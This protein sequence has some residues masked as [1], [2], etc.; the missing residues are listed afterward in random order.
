ME[1]AEAELDGMGTLDLPEGVLVVCQGGWL[2]AVGPYS[3]SLIVPSGSAQPRPV[4]GPSSAPNMPSPALNVM[5]GCTASRTWEDNVLHRVLLFYGWA[6]A[7]RVRR[8]NGWSSRDG[9]LMAALDHAL[10]KRDLAAVSGALSECAGTCGTAAELSAARRVAG[11]CAESWREGSRSFAAELLRQGS[12]FVAAA[13]VRLERGSASHLRRQLQED[14][15]SCLRLLHRLPGSRRRGPREEEAQGPRPLPLRALSEV[16]SGGALATNE[17]G[18]GALEDVVQE[19]VA[20][21][22]VGAAIAALQQ[23][24]PMGGPRG[25]GFSSL[26]WAGRRRTYAL[27][28][29]GD[30]DAGVAI[31]RGLGEDVRGAL[32]HLLES[33]THRG[34]RRSAAELLQAKGSLPPPARRL[35]E[36]TRM[37]EGLYRSPS[38]HRAREQLKPDGKGKGH[39]PL[40]PVRSAGQGGGE[41][42]HV[43]EVSGVVFGEWAGI[44]SGQPEEDLPKPTRGWEGYLVTTGRWAASMAERTLVRV[45]MDAL[46]AASG[47][48]G[49]PPV[50]LPPPLQGSVPPAAVWLAQAEYCMAHHRTARLEALLQSV[51]ESLSAMEDVSIT[52]G[53]NLE[54]AAGLPSFPILQ[55][56]SGFWEVGS[57]LA[58]DLAEECLL[59]AGFWPVPRGDV[60][61][62]RLL[63]LLARGQLLLPEGDAERSLPSV[64]WLRN[65]KVAQPIVD[66]L[67]GEW[68]RNGLPTLLREFMDTHGLALTPRGLEPLLALSRRLECRWAEWMLLSRIPGREEQFSAS[69]ANARAVIGEG[70]VPP[71][72][73]IGSL[74]DM[75]AHG[76]VSMALA[77]LMYAPCTVQEC[78]AAGEAGTGDP[79]ACPLELLEPGLRDKHPSLL[80]W[81]R[82]PR[83]AS[84]HLGRHEALLGNAGAAAGGWSPA[85]L[86]EA[87]RLAFQSARGG[88]GL[89]ELAR[90][91]LPLSSDMLRMLGMMVNGSP[92]VLRRAPAG[93]GAVPSASAARSEA[94]AVE[95]RLLDVVRDEFFYVDPEQ[96][97]GMALSNSLR[98]GRPMEAFEGWLRH[99]LLE[100]SQSRGGATGETGEPAGVAEAAPAAASSDP[101]GQL[102]AGSG[103]LCGARLERLVTLFAVS[104]YNDIGAVSASVALLSAGGL[105]TWPLRVDVA[106]LRRIALFRSSQLQETNTFT[107]NVDGEPEHRMTRDSFVEL[108]GRQQHLVADT[109]GALAQALVEELAVAFDEDQTEPGGSSRITSSEP[110]EVILDI[111]NHLE[112]TTLSL[113][114]LDWHC[115]SQDG[116]AS[117]SG[118]DSAAGSSPPPEPDSVFGPEVKEVQESRKKR[119]LLER[120]PLVTAFCRVHGI[121]PSTRLLRMF[122]LQG[123]WLHFLAEAQTQ[124]YALQDVRAVAQE[125][126]ADPNVCHHVCHVLSTLEARM[127]GGG[128][129]AASVDR[130]QPYESIPWTMS[131]ASQGDGGQDVELFKVVGKLEGRWDAGRAL[132]ERAYGLGWPLLAAVAGCFPDVSALECMV[133]WLHTTWQLMEA[134][135]PAVGS[136][137]IRQTS[138]LGAAPDP[139]PLKR[140]SGGEAPPQASPAR[141]ATVRLNQAWKEA[142]SEAHESASYRGTLWPATEASHLLVAVLCASRSF[143]TVLQGIELFLPSLPLLHL[144]RFLKYFTQMRIPEAERHLDAFA[145]AVSRAQRS[146]S[147]DG[148]GRGEAE[149]PSA[150]QHVPRAWSQAACSAAVES[151]LAALPTPWERRRLV[152]LVARLDPST[153]AQ[154]EGP[155]AVRAGEGAPPPERPLQPRSAADEPRSRLFRMLDLAYDLLGP[156]AEQY[157]YWEALCG[158][159]SASPPG[160][161]PELI[162]SAGVTGALKEARCWDDARQ[163]SK[164]P[165]AVT[166]AQAESLIKEWGELLGDGEDVLEGYGVWD[167]V[168]HLFEELSLPP[169]SAAQFFI[170]QAELRRSSSSLE[171]LCKI[172]QQA[173]A[174]MLASPAEPPELRSLRQLLSLLRSECL[175]PSAATGPAAHTLAALGLDR[176]PL[177]SLAK[178]SHEAPRRS[179][180]GPRDGPAQEATRDRI[181]QRKWHSTIE[182]TVRMLLEEGEV[183]RARELSERLPSPPIELTLVETA[184]AIVGAMDH[185]GSEPSSIDVVPSAVL[186]LLKRKGVLGE[187]EEEGTQAVL[188]ALEKVCK[189]G[190]G[191][192]QIARA[193]SAAAAAHQLGCLPKD[194][195]SRPP[196]E[197][198][199][200]LL[201]RGPGMLGLAARFAAGRDLSAAATGHLLARVFAESSTKRHSGP[202]STENGTSEMSLWQ[203]SNIMEAAAICD[204]NFEVGNAMMAVLLELSSAPAVEVE[205]MAMAYHFYSAGGCADG[206]DILLEMASGRLDT[207]AQKGDWGAVVGLLD[208]LGGSATIRRRALSHLVRSRRLKLLFEGREC[209]QE[210]PWK[211]GAA[212]HVMQLSLL[213]ALHEHHCDGSGT[214]E[215]VYRELRMHGSLASTVEARASEA[216]RVLSLS[217]QPRAKRSASLLG[218][219]GELLEA[220]EHYR[221][222][223]SSS[224]AAR[225]CRQVQL[226]AV[227]VRHPG[228]TLTGLSPGQALAAA[229]DLEPFADAY[230]LATLGGSCSEDDL[231]QILWGHLLSLSSR[232]RVKPAVATAMWNEYVSG[233]LS[234]VTLRLRVLQVVAESYRSWLGGE[235]APQPARHVQIV[236]QGVRDL[237]AASPNYR[238]RLLAFHAAGLQPEAASCRERLDLWS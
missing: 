60:Q 72:Q 158:V 37:L 109:A 203:P 199:D 108:N 111:L 36:T 184:E 208:W 61:L 65:A 83:S 101:S 141:A 183:K 173:V 149:D 145:D 76:S 187:S 92:R 103:M 207:W 121:P 230:T 233:F 26:L 115:P 53:A 229:Q 33:S 188:D 68:M 44:G 38:V 47:D 159:Q 114:G 151:V 146:D 120:W 148:P 98:R 157:I 85:R 2:C 166:L 143:D 31:L 67:A 22:A 213:A 62:P 163:W 217:S 139:R 140:I 77:T 71:P 196:P 201:R 40:G 69:F 110:S 29:S 6:A 210:E 35:W 234:L 24:D 18:G 78:L 4:L 206:R 194:I 190:C 135:E 186:D 216:L 84:P 41:L 172:L 133:A 232:R 3:I 124:S 79:W 235:Q 156:G 82:M 155:A 58:R 226:L 118:A 87:R 231:S 51:P 21:G 116:A 42:P 131:N 211:A 169:S 182:A 80:Q 178:V 130:R 180:Q 193:A 136:P 1:D 218:V 12:M 107:E 56:G 17:G 73:T 66:E 19:A 54:H 75:C 125:G 99:M 225:C 162:D 20:R 179:K 170:R 220:A 7:E 16:P 81:L 204:S 74:P 11:A 127:P 52:Y 106:A 147:A 50:E 45:V 119:G 142:F 132:L 112:E 134:E 117:I 14:L 223:G 238:W 191:R 177:G 185:R 161:P 9:L 174:W 91:F 175:S 212:P 27:L 228:E 209:A 123:D 138:A 8:A 128:M 10:E 13:I 171:E 227:Q 122:A 195:A 30:A 48:R 32:R 198:L 57:R 105:P 88:T 104:H 25:V 23:P 200:Q 70:D 95:A 150:L 94:A 154:E 153:W 167:E 192:R 215:M 236:T 113:D 224:S 59:R 100:Q 214:A 64:S 93:E 164:M 97:P 90:G 197:V 152:K 49:D 168:N 63:R 205:L 181:L 46:E 221:S 176:L 202:H 28:A 137:P 160:M 126:F 55:L 129:A 5:R 89:M 237:I 96:G 219:M 144:V 86:M 189:Q 102:P 222:A 165:H 15:A 39:A 43:A 34:V